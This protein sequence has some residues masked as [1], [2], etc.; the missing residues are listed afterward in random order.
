MDAVGIEIILLTGQ[1][2]LDMVMED[3][4]VLSVYFGI[5]ALTVAWFGESVKL[6]L[7]NLGKRYNL[8]I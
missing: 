8:Q 3:S 4:I 5:H 2:I 7:E 6:N 1:S